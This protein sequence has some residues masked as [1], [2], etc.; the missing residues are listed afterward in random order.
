MKSDKKDFFLFFDHNR[1]F[2]FFLAQYPLHLL[3]LRVALCGL[4]ILHFLFELFDTDHIAFD[5]MFNDPD[6]GVSDLVGEKE[7]VELGEIGV[8]LE[9]IQKVEC[10]FQGFFIVIT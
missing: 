6:G 4:Q 8:G 5:L 7:L 3:I 10:Q 2:F 9:D 1:Q